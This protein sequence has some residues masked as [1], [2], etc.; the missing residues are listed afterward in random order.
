MKLKTFASN[1]TRTHDVVVKESCFNHFTTK[2]SLSASQYINKLK[3]WRLFSI[4]FEYLN[5]HRPRWYQL[6]NISLFLKVNLRLN[7]QV[8]IGYKGKNKLLPRAHGQ[9]SDFI[10]KK[11]KILKFRQNVWCIL[12]LIKNNPYS[13]KLF[14]MINKMHQKFCRN[15][16]ILHFFG[17]KSEIYHG[18]FDVKDFFFIPNSNNFFVGRFIISEESSQVRK[19]ENGFVT[20]EL[21][22]VKWKCSTPQVSMTHSMSHSLNKSAWNNMILRLHCIVIEWK[23]IKSKMTQHEAIFL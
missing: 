9:I 12:F 7:S 21:K 2:H 8:I 14:L 10:P 1:E 22:D 18:I 11:C 17:I 3:N 4:Y 23:L 20:E 16:K 6:V 15:F 5:Y 13:Q 19:K